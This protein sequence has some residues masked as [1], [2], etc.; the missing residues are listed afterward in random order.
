MRLQA[1]WTDQRTDRQTDRQGDSYITAPKLCLQW[2]ND[3]LYFM[4]LFVENMSKEFLITSK[5]M[6]HDTFTL[7]QESRTTLYR[8]SNR[9]GKSK[10]FLFT[11]P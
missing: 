3:I 11:L 7:E 4:L 1:M 10:I 5:K 6:Y 9:K 8:K 2:Y